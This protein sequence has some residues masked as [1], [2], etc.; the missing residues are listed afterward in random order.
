MVGR[1][2]HSP[3]KLPSL[4][5]NRC[6]I[7]NQFL[8]L[9]FQAAIYKISDQFV[10]GNCSIGWKLCCRR[11]DFKVTVFALKLVR[12]SQ[13]LINQHRRDVK[14]SFRLISQATLSR[15]SC[16]RGKKVYWTIHGMEINLAIFHSARCRSVHE[17]DSAS[18]DRSPTY[19]YIQ[20]KYSTH[21]T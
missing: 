9:F 15:I 16:V 1:R 13:W 17:L 5:P 12:N 20:N 10:L 19:V 7:F 11:S 3:L 2:V 14:N 18:M 4:A 6:N 21:G 8:R